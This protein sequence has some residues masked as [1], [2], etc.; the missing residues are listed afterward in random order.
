MQQEHEHGIG[1]NIGV[2]GIM[3]IDGDVVRGAAGIAQVQEDT[4]TLVL[5]PDARILAEEVTRSQEFDGAAGIAKN[6]TTMRI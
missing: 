2:I 3:I 6:I 1:G 5:R 4:A